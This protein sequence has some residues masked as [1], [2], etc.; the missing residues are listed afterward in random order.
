M[1]TTCIIGMALTAL[2]L[3]ACGTGEDSGAASSSAEIRKISGGKTGPWVGSN[4]DSGEA[5]WTV[6]LGSIKC[7]VTLT[8]PEDA[9]TE[10]YSGRDGEK[11][12]AMAGSQHC[13]VRVDLTNDSKRPQTESPKPG[14]V[15]LGDAQ[16]APDYDL[17][18]FLGDFYDSGEF[19]GFFIDD[20]VQ[21]GETTA[22][23]Q[24]YTLEDGESIQAVEFSDEDPQL[25]L[26]ND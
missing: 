21:P 10:E 9:Y 23:F 16:L 12:E 1:K 13:L 24:L 20:P 3:G 2:A 26:T 5:Q 7:G 14:N 25:I 8:V 17:E 19:P 18:I 11:V 4:E 15:D 6:K 22:A